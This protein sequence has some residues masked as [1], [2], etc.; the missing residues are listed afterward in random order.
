[1]FRMYIDEVGNDSLTHT[2]KD[3]HRYLSLSGVIVDLEHVQNTLIPNIKRFKDEFFPTDP[4]DDPVIFHRTDIMGGKGP[5]Q[6]IRADE[7]FRKKFDRWLLRF[8]ESVEFKIIT[9]LIDKHWMIRQRHWRQDHP[10]H[11]IMAILVEKYVQ[12]LEREND[13]GDLMPES[14]GKHVDKSLQTA[15]AEV[16]SKGTNYVPPEKICAKIRS[17]NLKFRT[18]KD[19][20]AGLQLCDLVAHPS[21]IYTR[22]LAQHAVNLGPFSEKVIDIMKKEKYD[23]SENGRIKGYGVKFLQA[24][25]RN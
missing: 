1:M 6:K 16:K 23:R 12:F 19:N 8:I 9:V 5:F 15:F 18:K 24:I 3:K 25:T 22:R 21:H 13:I 20:I 11:Y 2:A 14:R 10:Y 7:E 17:D 4:D